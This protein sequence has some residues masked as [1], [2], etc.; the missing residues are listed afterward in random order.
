MFGYIR[1]LKDELKVREFE[2]FKTCYCALCHTL[3]RRYGAISRNILSYDFVFLAM[4]LWEDQGPPEIKCSRCAASPLKK[5]RYCAPSRVLDLCAGYNVI[6]TWWKLQD[7]IADERFC[8]SV[9]DR[10]LR[11]LLRGAYRK[12]SRAY[13]DFSEIVRVNI[14]SLT[15]LESDRNSQIGAN[16]SLDEF[17]DKFARITEAMAAVSEENGR[18]RPLQQLLYHTGRF[19]YIIDACD[20]LEEDLKYSRFNP[21]AKR[22]GRGEGSLTEEERTLM[23][24]TLMQSCSMI[25]TAFEILPKSFWSPVLSNII[26]LGMPQACANVLDGYKTDGRGARKRPRDEC[27]GN[28]GMDKVI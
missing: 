23:K 21:V 2:E 24:T 14:Q 27:A 18:R 15:E 1:P 9:R 12:A 4:L 17:A 7:S 28:K 10:L 16:P 6:L 13:A 19:V 8:R 26:Y 25:A 20:D 5:R 22:F 11:F 3:R